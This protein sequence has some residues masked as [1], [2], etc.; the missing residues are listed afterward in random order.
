MAN[1]RGAIIEGRGSFYEKLKRSAAAPPAGS[2]SFA[3]LAFG[4]F[5]I[6]CRLAV[7]TY[8]FWPPTVVICV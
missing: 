7:V 8:P 4:H 3:K 2:A 6:G 1:D 5:P